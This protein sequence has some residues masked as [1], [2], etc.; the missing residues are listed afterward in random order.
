MKIEMKI[1]IKN[2]FDGA[3]IL[4]IAEPPTPKREYCS[5]F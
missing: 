2:T 4:K 3:F 1:K 5:D